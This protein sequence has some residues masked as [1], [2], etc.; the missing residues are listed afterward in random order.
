MFVGDNQRP[1]FTPR[2]GWIS[3]GRQVLHFRPVRYDRWSQAL[4][5]T[6]GE[7]LP[8]EPIPLLKRRQDLSREQAVQLWKE[9]QQQGWR[10]CSAAWDPPPPRR[11]R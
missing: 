1:P 4:E 5:V 9:K 8:G 10:A 7:L 2:E 11:R 6:C 3:D